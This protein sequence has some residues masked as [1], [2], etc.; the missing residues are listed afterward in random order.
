MFQLTSTKR[1]AMKQ[2][3]LHLP[4][5]ILKA[6]LLAILDLRTFHNVVTRV[7]NCPRSI[8]SIPGRGHVYLSAFY[9]ANDQVKETKFP[10]IKLREFIF[11]IFFFFYVYYF[12][13][14]FVTIQ[15]KVITF[16]TPLVFSNTNYMTFVS[17]Q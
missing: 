5:A 4:A 12:L 2:I 8:I 6:A 1:K 7:I 16:P 11:L 15:N 13:I 3:E 17:S 14:V 10:K 9:G